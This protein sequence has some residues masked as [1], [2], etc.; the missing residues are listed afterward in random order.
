VRNLAL[1][2][3]LERGPVAG[4]SLETELGEEQGRQVVRSKGVWGK[5]SSSAIAGGGRARFLQRGL[6]SPRGNGP[7]LDVLEK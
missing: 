3:Q 7:N 1:L 2:Y 6:G 5:V 4:L